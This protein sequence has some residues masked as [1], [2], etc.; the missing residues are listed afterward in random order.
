MRKSDKKRD[1]A[2]RKVLTHVC[3]NALKDIPGF[4]WLTHM[5]NYDN[6][7]ESFRIVCIFD[8]NADL[9]NYLLSNNNDYLQSIIVSELSQM[10]VKLNS[11]KSQILFDTEEN[12]TEQDNGNWARRL[13]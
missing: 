3:E 10:D 5:V 8:S 7:P 2:L 6:F 11:I 12:C 13:G 1:N 4:S 9:D